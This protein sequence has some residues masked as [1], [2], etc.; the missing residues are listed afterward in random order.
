MA[1][2]VEITT[3]LRGNS[4]DDS[5][6]SVLH[7][8]K[9]R[10]DC[11]PDSQPSVIRSVKLAANISGLSTRNKVEGDTVYLITQKSKATFVS[12]R[13]VE[14]EESSREKGFFAHEWRG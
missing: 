11:N 4:K 2:V 7:K 10:I 12:Y 13:I 1:C 6:A 9:H 5:S 8:K 14:G 3:W